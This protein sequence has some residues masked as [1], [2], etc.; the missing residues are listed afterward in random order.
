ML[1]VDINTPFVGFYDQ[2]LPAM[3]ISDSTTARFFPT[4]YLPYV[5][6][7]SFSGQIQKHNQAGTDS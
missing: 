6:G 5:I 3:T 4:L 2:T 1:I 7:I